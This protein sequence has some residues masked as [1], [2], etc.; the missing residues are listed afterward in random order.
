MN[1]DIILDL[2]FSGQRYADRIKI[3][4]AETYTK[5]REKLEHKTKKLCKKMPKKDRDDL[6][7][8]ITLLQAKIESAIS[9]EY[10]KEGFKLGMTIAIQ[11][12]LD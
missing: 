2:V 3:D 8:D 4:D 7:W 12:F 10:F 6:L 9:E 5:C 11:C 1:K